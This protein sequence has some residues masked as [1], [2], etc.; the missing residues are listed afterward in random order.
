[1]RIRWCM[2]KLSFGV[3]KIERIQQGT[4]INHFRS[5]LQ[6]LLTHLNKC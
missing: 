6:L 5:F 1:M 3:R 4:G 2:E